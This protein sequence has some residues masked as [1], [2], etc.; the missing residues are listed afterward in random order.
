M[1][2]VLQK[3]FWVSPPQSCPV[4]YFNVC[5]VYNLRFALYHRLVRVA[6][7]ISLVA[8]SVNMIIRAVLALKYRHAFFTSVV[9]HPLGVLVTLLI[10]INSF[11]QVKRGRLEWKGRRINMQVNG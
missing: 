3:P 6:Y 4:F 2:R 1:E 7:K 10:G 8:I 9:L 11:Y 5:S